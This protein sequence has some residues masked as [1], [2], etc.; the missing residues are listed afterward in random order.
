M[1]LIPFLIFAVIAF[2]IFKGFTKTSSKPA[3][4]NGGNPKMM[5]RRLHQDIERANKGQKQGSHIDRYRQKSPTQQGRESFGHKGK[6][7]WG[8]NDTI[9]SGARVATKY[10]QKTKAARK[11]SHKSPEQ[12]GRRGRNVDQNRNRTNEWGQR[13][14]SGLLSVKA[15]IILLVLG[16]AALYVLS[17][18]PAS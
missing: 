12:H 7:P 9:S 13:G 18:M 10:V 11:A 3:V 2:N 4:K 1:E 8:E 6:S 15:V 17:H 14:D 16:G 5:M